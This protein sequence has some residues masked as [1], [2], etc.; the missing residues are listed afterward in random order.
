MLFTSAREAK[1]IGSAAASLLCNNKSSLDAFNMHLDARL[2]VSRLYPDT[3]AQH[4]T[5]FAVSIL[6]AR[7]SIEFGRQRATRRSR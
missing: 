6:L 1:I 5:N 7:K 3:T 4:E 2:D